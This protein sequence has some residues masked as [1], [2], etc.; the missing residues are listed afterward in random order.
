M[1][2]SAEIRQAEKDIGLPE[3]FVTAFQGAA[4]AL[5]ASLS[6]EL[7]LVLAAIVDDVHCAGVLYESFRSPRHD[8]VHP[9]L[10]RAGALVLRC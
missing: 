5:E 10:G 1:P 3:S 7:L 2:R 6:N 4:S 8:P 9:A